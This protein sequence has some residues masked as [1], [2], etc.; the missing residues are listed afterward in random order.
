MDPRSGSG[1]REFCATHR[2]VVAD[3]ADSRAAG[4]Q[5]ALAE[6]APQTGGQT[7]PSAWQGEGSR[8]AS[9]R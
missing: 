9:M 3:A 7:W 8:R 5:A 2:S 4:A 6:P 1:A